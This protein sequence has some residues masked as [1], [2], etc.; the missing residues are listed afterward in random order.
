LSAL[1]LPTA[2]DGF[3][4]AESPR[5]SDPKAVDFNRSSSSINVAQSN[6]L[7]NPPTQ[8]TDWLQS[9]ST[10]D[11]IGEFAH[12]QL[13][14]EPLPRDLSPA[15][16]EQ[17]IQLVRDNCD[18][19]S[20]HKFDL[21]CTDLV[22]VQIPTGDAQLFA[23]CLHSQPRAYSQAIDDEIKQLLK[24]DVIEP[25]N[26]SWNSNIVCVKKKIGDL[27]ICS[28]MRRLNLAH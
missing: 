12:M 7:H 21:G 3:A 10:S 16:R 2:D 11:N 23:E 24:A 22:E 26:S 15:Q 14:I 8:S 20:R 4:L 19:F 13:P 17:V 18:N 5:A 25:A 28:D 9:I 27:R 6:R 1:S